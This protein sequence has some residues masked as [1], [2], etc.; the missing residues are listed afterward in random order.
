MPSP[1]PSPKPSSVLVT[2]GSFARFDVRNGINVAGGYTSD[3]ESQGQT[4][5]VNASAVGS[6]YSALRADNISAPTTVSSITANGPSLS[7]ASSSTA[8]AVIVQNHTANLTLTDL[9]INGG[10]GPSATGMLVQG[11][12]S[13]TVTN[14]TISS[15]T[16]LGNGSSAYGLRVI[17]SS[18]AAVNGGSITA[19]AGVASLNSTAA[20]PATPP[21]SCNGANGQNATGPSSPGSGGSG[22]EIRHGQKRQWRPRR[23]LHVGLG[24]PDLQWGRT[25]SERRR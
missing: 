5:T 22:C 4:T 20:K 10:Q 15:G 24:C 2:S 21:K 6:Q 19:S 12:S 13:A 16:T 8:Q 7:G 23:R 11:A 3:F 17:G 18:A 25:G 1:K 9:V 14:S